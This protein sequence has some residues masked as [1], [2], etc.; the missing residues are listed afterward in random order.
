VNSPPVIDPSTSQEN[1][2]NLVR[3]YLARASRDLL[4]HAKRCAREGGVESK[5]FAP[6]VSTVAYEVYGTATGGRCEETRPEVEAWVE[7]LSG[8][9]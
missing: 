7:S 8:E 4:V 3:D 5:L 2:R 6:L 9:A 1:N